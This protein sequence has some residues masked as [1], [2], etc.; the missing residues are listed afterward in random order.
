MSKNY[1][2]LSKNFIPLE[3]VTENLKEI[4][5]SRKLEVACQSDQV[6]ATWGTLDNN[7]KNSEC[8]KTTNVL[9]KMS[10]L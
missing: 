5:L 1:Q 8:P 4:A 3:S 2:R 9:E 10:P 7:P 6:E